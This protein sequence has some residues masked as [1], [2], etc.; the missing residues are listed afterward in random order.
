MKYKQKLLDQINNDHLRELLKTKQVSGFHG[1][2][3][4]N[5]YRVDFRDG[6]SLVVPF[7]KIFGIINTEKAFHDLSIVSQ[8]FA[9]EE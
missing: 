4:D 1:S 7:E 2:N 5:N 3:Y 6:S 9:Y 8:I